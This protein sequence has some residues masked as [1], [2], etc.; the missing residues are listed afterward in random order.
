M[1][2]QFQSTF[3]L[4]PE[5]WDFRAIPNAALSN[6]TAWEYAI[7]SDTVRNR[8]VAFLE[9]EIEP[10]TTVRQFL[11]AG[12]AKIQEW[13]PQEAKL[14]HQVNQEGIKA[15]MN[16]RLW[17]LI[18]IIPI[19]P[20]H[21]L[22]FNPTYGVNKRYSA[23]LISRTADTVK[24]IQSRFPAVDQMAFFAMSHLNDFLM[25]VDWNG[26]TVDE[27]IEHFSRWIRVEAKKHPTMKKAGKRSQAPKDKLRWLAAFRL[28]KVGMTYEQA[29]AAL[30]AY[31]T[32]LQVDIG[33]R[34][35]LP[36][37]ENPSSWSEAIA[38]ARDELESLNHADG[39][40]K[41]YLALQDFL[42]AIPD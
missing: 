26:H 5:C 13:T 7:E 29:Y 6:A 34:T 9:S 22:L 31:I 21:W 20:K 42:F 18:Q 25:R 19:F 15:T 23:I 2:I 12:R 8:I 40:T 35:I 28:S 4:S 24:G 10:K 36:I 32:K 11:M 30:M 14:V 39:D 38:R 37:F 41:Q 16:L 3:P 33:K 17:E 27:L 1:N